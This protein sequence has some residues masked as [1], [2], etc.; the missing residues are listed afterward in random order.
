VEIFPGKN[1]SEMFSFQFKFGGK[2]ISRC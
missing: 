2:S 1:F